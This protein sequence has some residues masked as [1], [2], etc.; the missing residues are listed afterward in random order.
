MYTG[1]LVLVIAQVVRVVGW[2]DGAVAGSA[3]AFVL[4]V[5]GYIRGLGQRK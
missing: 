4:I 2:N 1:V 3:V 5:F